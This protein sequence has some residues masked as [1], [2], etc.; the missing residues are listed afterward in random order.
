MMVH[1][2]LEDVY[3]PSL[4][5]IHWDLCEPPSDFAVPQVEA[6]SDYCIFSLH[7]PLLMGYY[8]FLIDLLCFYPNG[9]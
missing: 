2:P 5:Y 8:S 7:N 1:S 4:I 3:D 9:A 6:A